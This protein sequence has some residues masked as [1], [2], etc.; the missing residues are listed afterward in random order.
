MSGRNL[1]RTSR[2]GSAGAI[3]AA[4]LTLAVAA[5]AMAYDH[6]GGGEW[7]HGVTRTS[8]THTWSN[9]YNALYYHSST[10]TCGS[11]ADKGY[12]NA[13]SWSWA[14]TWCGYFEGTGAYW[15]N[16]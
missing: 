6:V 8:G 14:Q 11:A 1:G 3:A 7:D 2:R 13:G 12:N 5:P 15:S 4:L 16:Y 9:Y 10:S